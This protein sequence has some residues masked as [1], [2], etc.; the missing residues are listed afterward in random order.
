MI[1]YVAEAVAAGFAVAEFVV[2]EF[3][4]V[5]FAVAGSAV[6]GFAVVGSGGFDVVAYAADVATEVYCGAAVAE[7]VVVEVVVA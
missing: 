7:N 3:A 2:V 4:G 1:V 6:A 5:E